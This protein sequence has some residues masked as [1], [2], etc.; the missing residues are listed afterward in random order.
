MQ[1]H[2]GLGG[3]G[4]LH[5]DGQDSVLKVGTNLA[6]VC[7]LWH[8]HAARHPAWINSLLKAGQ[9]CS[10]ADLP[11]HLQPELVMDESYSMHE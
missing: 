7:V 11:A 6:Q 9:D 5:G 4:A 8:L 3:L 1:A 2:L 10:R